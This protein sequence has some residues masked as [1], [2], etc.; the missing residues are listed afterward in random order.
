VTQ[1]TLHA[2]AQQIAE[3]IALL[4][5]GGVIA[6]PTDTVYG[7]AAS[8]EHPAAI[9]RIFSIKGRAG[10]KALPV[11]IDDMTQLERFSVALSDQARALA[12]AFWPGALTIVVQA[13]DWVPDAI[14]RGGGT[15]GL[16]MPD[17]ADTLAIITGAGG[18]LVVTSANRSGDR[19]ARSAAEAERAL[20]SRLDLIV[21]GGPSPSAAPSTVVD[22]SGPR[23]TV[24]RVGAIPAARIDAVAGLRH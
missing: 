9:E 17:C 3:A 20:G 13:A 16:R 15:V 23:P 21:D 8:V 24:L 19:E 22:A 11:L 2:T 4:Q 6:L 12:A 1:D 18:A 5:A 10:T 14:L 7:I